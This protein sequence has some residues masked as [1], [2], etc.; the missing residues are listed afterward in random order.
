MAAN[1]S[2]KGVNWLANNPGFKGS[3]VDQALSR[4]PF[5]FIDIGARGGVHEIVEPVARLTKVL[6]FEPDQAACEELRAELSRNSSWAAI[7]L[8]P[9]ALAGTEGFGDLHLMVT[10][11]NHSLLPGNK[12]VVDRYNIV[13]LKEV[14]TTKVPTTTLDNC[15]LNKRQNDARSGEVIK[16]DAQG[17]E[18]DIMQAGKTILQNRT[19]AIFTE[20]LFFEL[21]KGQKLFSE[22][23][24]YLRSLGFSFYG[25]PN[26]HFRSKK[27]LDK[28]IH[29]GAERMIYADAVFF[30]DPLA[31]NPNCGPLDERQQMI[32]F[33]FALVLGYFDFALE[34]AVETFGRADKDQYRKLVFD[35]AAS[36][37]EKAVEEATLLA[38][39]TRRTP[40]LANVEVGRFVDERR[41]YFDYDDYLAAMRSQ[42]LAN[43]I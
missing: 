6:C 26:L 9:V 13:T 35:L 27:G 8:E 39:R 16:F 2:R 24:L 40:D 36:P 14:G 21:Y 37:P 18:F 4:E 32:L 12:S 15:L 42:E 29:R 7:E 23:E 5:G 38:E 25:F 1:K 11:T 43:K 10:P 31:G 19:L 33:T 20:V 22:I 30:K 28:R 34:L 17:A 3:S 41:K